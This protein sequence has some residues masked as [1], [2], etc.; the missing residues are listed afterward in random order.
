[1]SRPVMIARGDVKVRFSMVWRRSTRINPGSRWLAR[2][3][4]LYLVAALAWLAAPG[5]PAQAQQAKKTAK[6]YPTGYSDTPFL[7][8]IRLP[9][10]W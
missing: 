5:N 7:P 10:R 2:A 6:D 3:L 8:G 9:L 1:M 4:L